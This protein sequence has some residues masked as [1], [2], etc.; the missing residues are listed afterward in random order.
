[1]LSVLELLK[2][3]KEAFP[4]KRIT[5]SHLLFVWAEAER[6]TVSRLLSRTGLGPEEFKRTL[7]PFIEEPEEGDRELLLECTR[8]SPGISPSGWHLLDALCRKP[9]HRITQALIQA[10]LNLEALKRNLAELSPWAPATVFGKMAERSAILKYGRD[11]TEEAAT[12]AFDDLCP[13]PRELGKLIQILLRKERP[14]PVLT[15]PAGVGKTALVELLAREIVRGRAPQKLA[16]TR[17]LA[18]NMGKLVAGTKYRGQLEERFEELMK[19]LRRAAPA[20]LFIDEFHLVW[21]AGRAEGAPLD[22][23]NM[24]KSEL[25]SGDIRIIG[26]TTSEEYHRYIERDAALARRFTELPLTE[27]TGELLREILEKKRRAL[28]EHHGISI[29]AS[30]LPRAIELTASH[31]PNRHQPAK[32]VDLLDLSAAKVASRGGTRLTEEDL[33]QALEDITGRP[34]ASPD[35]E[36]RDRLLKLGERLKKK[37]VGQDEAIDKVVATL[38]YRRQRFGEE[39][40]NLGSFLFVGSTGVGKTALALALAEELFGGKEALLRLDMAEYRG[41][42]AIPKLIGTALGLPSDRE[43][44]LTGWLYSHGTGVILFDEIEKA[45]REVQRLLLGMLDR[46]RIRD[47]QGRELDTRQCVIIFTTNAVR[48]EFLK[49]RQPG[50]LGPHGDNPVEVAELLREE[51]PRE[52]LGRLDE[53]ILFNDLGDEELKRILWLNLEEGLGR[54]RKNGVVVE[55][56][57]EALLGYLLRGLK[58]TG[59]SGARGVKRVLERLFFQPLAMALA[60][61]PGTRSVR[62]SLDA[63]GELTWEL[64]G[65]SD[66]EGVVGG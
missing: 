48:P 1:M 54:F 3:A 30:I 49:R 28:E 18:L 13:R 19:T 59:G 4:G 65:G 10:G 36:E 6:D 40:R 25:N 39:E 58:R 51:F 52:F 29:P 45:D 7:K 34:V 8:G 38:I 63:K 12:G 37:I 15:G 16:G 9:E 21:G 42:D 61:A 32:T 64:E 66:G 2:K 5:I 20:I 14:N 50:F 27:P 23:A 22:V 47:A 55:Y 11:L 57:R 44:A 53:V 62:V 56:D 35:N 33:L 24:L 26:A 43:G 17:V 31:L 46:G 41:F 60:G